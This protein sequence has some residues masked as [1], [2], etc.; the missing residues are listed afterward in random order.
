MVSG[1]K[2]RGTK[3]GGSSVLTI[4]GVVCFATI[5]VA[6]LLITSVTIDYNQTVEQRPTITLTSTGATGDLY[7]GETLTSSYQAVVSKD[8][9]GAK[10]V[11]TVTNDDNT[12]AS[13][14]FTGDDIIVN[15][16]VNQYTIHVT[17]FTG[18]V[19]H[20]ETLVADAADVSGAVAD[21]TYTGSVV[22]SYT[23]ADAF[24]LHVTMTGNV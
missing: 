2:F 20:G 4:L 8:L 23:N 10:I 13:G 5:L 12:V 11:V 22:L 17:D 1:M 24:A 21:A 7:V 9:T 14:D 18:G 15:F 6:A 16:G 19:A 3:I